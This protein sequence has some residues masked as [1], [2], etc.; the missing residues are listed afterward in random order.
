MIQRREMRGQQDK[1]N[2]RAK[3]VRE[4]TGGKTVSSLFMD[5]SERAGQQRGW[6]RTYISLKA[7]QLNDEWSSL[8]TQSSPV[9]PLQ[10][11][12]DKGFRPIELGRAGES[13]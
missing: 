4:R 13:V 6:K 8:E 7:S 9:V 1:A 12:H 10:P 5:C 3:A 11:E 2:N